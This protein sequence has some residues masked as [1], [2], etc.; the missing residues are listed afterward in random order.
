[1]RIGL[2]ANHQAPKSE[3]A[4]KLIDGTFKMIRTAEEVGFNHIST[5]QHF[6]SD[7]TQ[8]Q[9]FPYLARVTAEVDSIDIST[10]AV[11]LPLQHPIAVAERIATLSHMNNGGTCLGIGAGYRDVEFDNFGV[12]KSERGKRV[13]E[14]VQ[15]INRL[16]TETNVSFDGEFYSVEDA[17]LSIE[18]AE[19]I[20]IWIAANSDPAVRR[21]ARL[22]DGW[23]VNPHSTIS[24]IEQQKKDVYDP[25]RKESDKSTSVPV[26]RECFVAPSTEEAVEVSRK[27]L[28]QKYARYVEWGQH[29]A[30]EDSSELQQQF[31]ALAENR[32]VLGTPSEVC[33]ELE[34]YED[35]LDM[36]LA[37]LRLNWPGLPYDRACECI[38]L[39]GD[40]VIPYV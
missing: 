40:E 38:E 10:G 14:G 28:E 9:L 35:R 8:P 7:F 26:I 16:L 29:E 37:L 13:E 4:S 17:T 31:D 36:D 19:N 5:G 11:V 34:R 6:L 15:L 23:F 20:P 39:I 12:S 1:M 3:S 33:A 2:F 30:M 22:S 27:Y 24:E 25:I 21:A 32:F 18:P